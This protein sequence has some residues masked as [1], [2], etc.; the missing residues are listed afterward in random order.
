[1]VNMDRKYIKLEEFLGR[2]NTARTAASGVFL[3]TFAFI[4]ALCMFVVF[5]PLIGITILFMVVLDLEHPLAA[6]TA[7]GMTL[8]PY[9]STSVMTIFISVLFLAIVGHF[10][11]PYLKDLV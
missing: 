2:V 9:S 11:K 5:F 6:G 10:S 1:M 7:L 8:I 3:L 4:W